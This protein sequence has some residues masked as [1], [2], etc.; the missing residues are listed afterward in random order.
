LSTP[1][2]KRQAE[3]MVSQHTFDDTVTLTTAGTH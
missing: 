3:L 2:L 1:A